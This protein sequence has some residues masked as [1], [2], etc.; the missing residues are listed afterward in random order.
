MTL[1]E[2]EAGIRSRDT[3]LSAYL[4]GKVL[5]QAKPDDALRFVPLII[6]ETRWSEIERYL[7]DRR[8]FWTWILTCWKARRDQRS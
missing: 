8:D 2:F 1:V 3:E 4:L 6:L 5:R 7:G